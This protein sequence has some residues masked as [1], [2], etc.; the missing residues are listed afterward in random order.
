MDSMSR[1]IENILKVAYLAQL[2]FSTDT[3]EG[4]AKS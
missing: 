2:S 1:F 4:F 3:R